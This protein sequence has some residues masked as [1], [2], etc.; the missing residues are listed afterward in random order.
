MTWIYAIQHHYHFTIQLPKQDHE[1]PKTV[2]FP[3]L[4]KIARI[5]GLQTSMRAYVFNPLIEN[6]VCIAIIYAIVNLLDVKL[7]EV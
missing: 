6:S 4:I 7:V 1:L 2:N 3:I 5:D